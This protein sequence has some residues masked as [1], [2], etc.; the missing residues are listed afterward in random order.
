LNEEIIRG[1][2][3]IEAATVVRALIPPVPK[4]AE[5]FKYQVL[6]GGSWWEKGPSIVK[7][8]HRVKLT[9]IIGYGRLEYLIMLVKMPDDTPPDVGFVVNIDGWEIEDWTIYE[10][11]EL[12]LDKPIS[13]YAGVLRYDTANKLYSYFSYWLMWPFTRSLRVEIANFTDVDVE[14]VMWDVQFFAKHA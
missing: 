14:L 3:R 9:E 6:Y 12:G 4:V 5:G 2:E 13:G 1:L 10:A 7:A 11:H 8:G